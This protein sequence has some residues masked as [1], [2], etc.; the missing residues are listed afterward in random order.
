MNK[1]ITEKRL[2]ETDVIVKEQIVCDVCG[3]LI[4]E[5]KDKAI[6]FCIGNYWSLYK[7]HNEFECSSLLDL[8]SNECVK[9]EF[10]KYINE[11]NNETFELEPVFQYPV[12]KKDSLF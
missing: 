4:K 1:K 3:K 12:N 9:E 2:I 5:R 8:C 6:S 10:E 11:T 7:Y